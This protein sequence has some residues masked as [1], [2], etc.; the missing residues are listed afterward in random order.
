[1]QKLEVIKIKQSETHPLQLVTI[2]KGGQNLIKMTDKDDR[3]EIQANTQKNYDFLDILE[4]ELSEVKNP[5]IEKE[6]QIIMICLNVNAKPIKVS[7]VVDQKAK[8]V[9][10]YDFTHTFKMYYDSK[11]KMPKAGTYNKVILKIKSDF[12]EFEETSK[13]YLKIK[14]NSRQSKLAEYTKEVN[15]LLNIEGYKVDVEI[16]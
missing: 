14:Y 5:D 10:E 1:M 6:D 15:D 12:R 9:W 13:I 16:K 3:M 7:K 4:A 11:E 8:T 2:K